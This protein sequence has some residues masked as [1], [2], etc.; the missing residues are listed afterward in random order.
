MRSL[1]LNIAPDLVLVSHDEE[2]M[3]Q[4]DEYSRY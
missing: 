1:V 2:A 3:T 4:T